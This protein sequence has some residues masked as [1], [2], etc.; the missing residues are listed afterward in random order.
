MAEA[1]M[2]P[3]RRAASVLTAAKVK[4]AAPGK[5]HDGGGLG[6]ILRVDPNGAR[7]WVQRITIHGKR[8]EL[9]LGSPP[10]VSLADARDAALKNK[11]LLR[12]GADPLAEKRKAKESIIFSEAV[13]RYLATKLAEFE[14]EKHRKQ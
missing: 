12:A 9:G 13:E 5:Y 6:L 4:S 11:R 2:A 10:V 7:F 3:K 8:R 1:E 14:N